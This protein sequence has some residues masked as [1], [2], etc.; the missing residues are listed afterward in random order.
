MTEV[1]KTPFQIA[2]GYEP[3]SG[4]LVGANDFSYGH[5]AGQ[6]FAAERIAREIADAEVGGSEVVRL[7]RSVR[8][9]FDDD[10]NFIA[11]PDDGADP[12]Q[13]IDRFL[14]ALDGK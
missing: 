13:E 14:A 11:W 6:M 8:R 4:D 3:E 2:D 10:G 12:I 1:Q 9:M 5:E 7:L